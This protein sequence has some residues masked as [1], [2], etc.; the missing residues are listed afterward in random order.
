LDVI[1]AGADRIEI[2]VV[3]DFHKYDAQIRN[4]GKMED[5]TFE[6]QMS[7]D[8]WKD[9]P[10]RKDDYLYVDKT[11]FGGV[12]RSV[13]KDTS[14]RTM[15]VKGLTWRG[16]L[17]KKVI[18]P[19][20]GQGYRIYTGVSPAAILSDVVGDFYD[21]FEVQET[22]HSPISAQYRYQTILEGITATFQKNG[23]SLFVQ[24]DADEMKCILKPRTIVDYSGLYDI[25]ADSG[26]GITIEDNGLVT[27]NHVIGLGRGEL[28]ERQVVERW[29]YDGVIYTSR[30]SEI[31]EEKQDTL[32]YDYSSVESLED[33]EDGAEQKLRESQ[34][35]V[36]VNVGTLTSIDADLELGDVITVV[37]ADMGIDIKKTVS[38]KILTITGENEKIET[39]VS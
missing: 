11:E 28:V 30:P 21:V 10:I 29:I 13:R 12:V 32:V 35:T 23:M 15:T 33:L 16:I 4:N 1:H 19:P 18:E 26:I 38:Q 22:G 39:G 25:S 34:P 5:N 36:S 7:I 6:L 9:S 2:G 3:R 20:S 24:Y 31:P 27:Y 8:A 14:T 37:D 17:A